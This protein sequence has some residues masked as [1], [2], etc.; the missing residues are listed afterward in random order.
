MANDDNRR[1]HERIPVSKSVKTKTEAGSQNG[2]ITDISVGGAAIV[3]Q[4]PL[5]IGLGSLWNCGL[6][7]KGTFPA[8]SCAR[9]VAVISRL[10]SIWMKMT[11][12]RSS[13]TL[14][15]MTGTSS[16][17]LQLRKQSGAAELVR[18]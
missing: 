4:G 9:M 18:P 3:N 6:R 15:R 13:T 10:R 7:T 12:G 14:Q 2:E 5:Q 16:P 8:M 17:L 11:L 1:Q